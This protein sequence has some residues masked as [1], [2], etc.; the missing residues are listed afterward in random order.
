[1][2]DGSK[3]DE[4]IYFWNCLFDAQIHRNDWR[5]VMELECMEVEKC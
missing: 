1:M 2:E 5:R 3:K 4:G